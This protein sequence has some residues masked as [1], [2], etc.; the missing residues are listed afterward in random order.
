MTFQK[1]AAGHSVTYEDGTTE[2][3]TEKEWKKMLARQL[4]AKTK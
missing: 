3:L 4:K 1:N 2:M